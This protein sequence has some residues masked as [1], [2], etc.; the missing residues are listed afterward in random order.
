MNDSSFFIDETDKKILMHKD[1]HFAGSLQG[2]L[3]YYEKDGIGIQEEFDL[4]RIEML[5]SLQQSTDSSLSDLLLDQTD[6]AEIIR[7]KQAYES[8]QTL[9]DSKPSAAQKLALL[10]LSEEEEPE[11]EIQQ[12]CSYGD[13]AI[14]PLLSVIADEDFYNPLFPGYGTAPSRAALCLGK[15]KAEKAII[16]LFESLS[17]TEFFGEEAV[18]KALS[19]IGTPAK[20]F[21]LSIL[22]KTPLTK[23]NENAALALTFFEKDDAVS[24]CCI[25][26]LYLP[27]VQANPT[28]FTYLLGS[29]EEITN[30]ELIRRLI[31][32]SDG[33]SSDM[34]KEELQLVL[35]S[36]V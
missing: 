11:E 2:M 27:S 12:L 13:A 31:R 17:L 34:L 16:P 33:L 32:L 21:L 22:K 28:F 30:P 10:I 23:D 29:C 5:L 19:Q 3:A 24:S 4:Q 9:C 20:Q 26:L 18:F 35:G 36:M 6:Q 25:D 1:V 15:L 8:L 14:D 7:A